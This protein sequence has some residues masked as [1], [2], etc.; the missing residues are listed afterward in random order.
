MFTL[1]QFNIAAATATLPTETHATLQAADIIEFRMDLAEDPLEEV[2]AY[3]GPHPLIVTNRPDWEGGKCT[4]TESDRLDSLTSASRHS[5]VRMVDLELETLAT[6]RGEEAMKR[7]RSNDVDIIASVHDFEDTPPLSVLEKKLYQAASHGT[8]AKLATMANTTADGMR[9]LQATHQASGWGTHIA[10]MAMGA[11]GKHTRVV[12]PLYGSKIGYA[13]AD[14][15]EA[16]APGQLTI[17]ELDTV[18]NLVR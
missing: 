8:V 13:P 7:I 3:S 15:T 10:T 14:P 12:A 16:T 17:E 4:D 5:A 1:D 6:T 18:L 2:R 9:L 11:A